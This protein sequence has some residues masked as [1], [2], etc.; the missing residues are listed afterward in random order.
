MDELLLYFV[1]ITPGL[2]V[3][4]LLFFLIPR[5]QIIF[6]ILVLILGFIL[7]RDAM[8]P[9]GFWSFGVTDSVTWIRFTN[10]PLILTILG[11]L[12]LATAFLL[13]KVKS[14]NPLVRWGDVGSWKVYTVGL[15]AGV[16]VALPFALLSL[17]VPLE[18]RGGMVAVSLLPALLFMS[19]AGNFLEELI[20]RGFLQGHLEKQMKQTRVAIISGLTFAAAHIFLAST[21][22][23]LG[24]PLIVFVLAEG[25]VCAFVY[26]KYGLISA[27]IVHGTAI[28]LLA[29]GIF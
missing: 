3:V 26:K 16:G 29:A 6:R 11:I 18:A 20:F 1:R 9:A 10:N 5:K 12:S 27:S 21:V 22:T 17:S 24:W 13:L 23:N 19:F 7:M 15:V 14:L 2:L 28:F 25:L 4:V 8:T